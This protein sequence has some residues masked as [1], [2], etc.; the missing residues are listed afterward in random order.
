MMTEHDDPT[1]DR[2]KHH[3]AQR[4][5]NQARQVLEVWQ[6]LTR[7]EWNSD[8]MEELADA[9]LRLQRYAE[10]F[11]QAEH[12]QLAGAIDRTLDVVEAN[13]GRL[14]SESISELNQLMQ[15]LSRTGL[16]HGDQL[17]HTVLPP[18]RKPVYLALKDRERAERL[19]Q[20]L[21]FFGLQA[22]SCETADAFRASM[23]ERYPA[24]IVME[25]DFAGPD[26][27]LRLASEAQAGL[28]PDRVKTQQT[29]TINFRGFSQRLGGRRRPNQAQSII[30][31]AMALSA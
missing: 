11:E 28:E 29:M 31:V 14:S 19:A 23:R 20:Q 30:L 10:R 22:L 26:M 25:V 15:R 21:E 6:R 18:L 3:F 24:A 27:G 4:V 12:A 16:R 2:L 5:I 17:E 1:L 8:G 9:T 7:A 13:R